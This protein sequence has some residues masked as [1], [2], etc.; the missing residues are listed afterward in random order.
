MLGAFPLPVEVVPFGLAATQRAV[1]H[2]GA[3]AGCAGEVALRRGADGHAFVTD[4]GHVSLD[5]HFGRIA[6]PAALAG[7]LAAIPGVM[8]HGL[9]I[10][11]AS[12]AIIAGSDGISRLSPPSF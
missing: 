2:A 6:L 3:D 9:F 7:N 10:G 8:A 5:A 4:S 11:L 1:A 12:E